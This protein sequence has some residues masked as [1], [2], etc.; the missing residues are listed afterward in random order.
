MRHPFVALL[1][2]SVVI[3]ICIRVINKNLLSRR[4]PRTFQLLNLPSAIHAYDGIR[5]NYSAA[6]L[7]K[8]GF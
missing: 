2:P 4:Y 5:C 8:F 1:F 7:A 3:D 6:T